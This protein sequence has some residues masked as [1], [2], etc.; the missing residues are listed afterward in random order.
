[1]KGDKG[2]M[3]MDTM[4]SEMLNERWTNVSLVARKEERHTMEFHTALLA[5]YTSYQAAQTYSQLFQ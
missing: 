1:M 2:K 5:P 4:V 3:R